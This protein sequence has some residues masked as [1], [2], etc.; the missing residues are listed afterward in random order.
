LQESGFGASEPSDEHGEYRIYGL[1]AGAYILKA[2]QMSQP[3]GVALGG[4]HQ[5]TEADI[6]R[7]EEV[8]SGRRLPTSRA[9]ISEDGPPLANPLTFAPVFYPSVFAP[10]D[11]SFVSVEA[12]EERSGIDIQFR[13]AP[14]AKVHGTVFGPDGVMLPGAILTILDP[15]PRTPGVIAAAMRSTRS[16]GR[17]DFEFQAV[18]PGH[19]TLLADAVSGQ[20][21]I[22]WGSTEITLNGLDVTAPILLS[23]GKPV[24]GRIVFEGSS[25]PS[26]SLANPILVPEAGLPA[27]ASP[28]VVSADGSF[29][30]ASVAPGSY[31]IVMNGGPPRGWVVQSIVAEGR[32][33]L[34]TPLFVGTLE[35]SGVTITLSDHPTA[36]SGTLLYSSGAPALEYVL[37]VFPTDP[38]LWAILGRWSSSRRLLA[39]RRDR[40][41]GW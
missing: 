19:Y 5:T 36:F 21:Q 1:A 41:I 37:I 20:A 18:G 40:R 7:A 24:S 6:R 17:G 33:L 31:R 29:T 35:V 26:M 10:S 9:V 25:R 3:D 12:Q 14:T 28:P 2:V 34:D 23:P 8:M 27:R 16:D 39:R 4:V 22:L 15:G 11:A 32:D 30:F 13:L 38:H